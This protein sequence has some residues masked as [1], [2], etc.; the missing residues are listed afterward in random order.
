MIDSLIEPEDQHILTGTIDSGLVG[1]SK[2][3]KSHAIGLVAL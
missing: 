2:K 3:K 1:L